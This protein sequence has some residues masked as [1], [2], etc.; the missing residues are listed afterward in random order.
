MRMRPLGLKQSLMGL[1]LAAGSSLPVSAH[2][3]Y[4]GPAGAAHNVEHLAPTLALIVLLLAL[5]ATAAYCARR[6]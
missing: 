1:V 3:I 6:N 2:Y 5:G 4:G